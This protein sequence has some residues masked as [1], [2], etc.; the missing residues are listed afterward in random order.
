MG[1]VST[2]VFA[3]C[4]TGDHIVAQNRTFSV[5]NQ[6]LTMVCPRFGIDVTFVDASD[7]GAVEAPVEPAVVEPLGVE[8]LRAPL[9][10][11]RGEC[12]LVPLVV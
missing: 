12:G 4:S 9:A 5:T 11:R 2:I 8:R 10:A 1:A 3:L 6:L 7:V